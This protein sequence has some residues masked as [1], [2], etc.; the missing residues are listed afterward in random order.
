MTSDYVK[1][2]GA[3]FRVAGTRVSLDSIVYAFR[4]GQS[5]ESIAENYPALTLE[6][7]YGALAFYLRRQKEIDDYLRRE[8]AADEQTRRDWAA[9]PSNLIR[10]LRRAR[11]ASQV[12]G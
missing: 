1:K 2:V 7:V 9:D 11:D 4:E 8:E 5:A 3:T 6:Q 10:K 12:P